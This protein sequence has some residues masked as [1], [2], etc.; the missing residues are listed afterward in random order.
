LSE[1]TCHFVNLLNFAGSAVI[2]LSAWDKSRDS[3]ANSQKVED[4]YTTYTKLFLDKSL[5]SFTAVGRGS[6]GSDHLLRLLSMV[7]LRFWSKCGVTVPC[8]VV[9]WTKRSIRKWKL[10]KLKICIWFLK[11]RAWKIKLD[12][13][14]FLS[15][16]NLNFAGC[17]GSKNEIRPTWFFKLNFSKIKPRSIGDKFLSNLWSGCTL[18]LLWANFDQQ[19]AVLWLVEIS[20][21]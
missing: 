17:T 6:R 10:E 9:L 5:L 3:E 1:N 8:C 13:L 21:A 14:D 16:L 19:S 2:S 7:N 12:E 4:M 15:I 18:V 20:L 11:N